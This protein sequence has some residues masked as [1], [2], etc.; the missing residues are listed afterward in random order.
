MHYIKYVN[1]L[2]LEVPSTTA[3]IKLR[4]PTSY[5]SITWYLVRNVNSLTPPTHLTY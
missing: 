2:C 5:M 1:K 4:P 3:Q